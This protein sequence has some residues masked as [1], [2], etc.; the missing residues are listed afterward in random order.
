M[1][2]SIFIIAAATLFYYNVYFSTGLANNGQQLVQYEFNFFAESET[3]TLA[4]ENISNPS[5]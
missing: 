5:N 2:V 3:S 4:V 1:K